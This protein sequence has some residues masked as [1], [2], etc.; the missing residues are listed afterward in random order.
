MPYLIS[1]HL[2]QDY[3]KISADK[4]QSLSM[5]KKY[6]NLQKSPPRNILWGLITDIKKSLYQNIKA[7]KKGSHAADNNF[8]LIFFN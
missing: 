3:N 4:L 6:V 2:D 7:E 1:L 8:K 5:D